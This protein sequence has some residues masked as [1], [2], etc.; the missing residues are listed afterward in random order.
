MLGAPHRGRKIAEAPGDASIVVLRLREAGPRELFRLG[1]HPIEDNRRA[2]MRRFRRGQR[3]RS[4]PSLRRLDRGRRGR[5]QIYRARRLARRTFDAGRQVRIGP[6]RFSPDTRHA[7]SPIHLPRYIAEAL[8]FD[9]G[10]STSED[11]RG[12]LLAL[13]PSCYKRRSRPRWADRGSCAYP[14]RDC[15]PASNVVAPEERPGSRVRRACPAETGKRSGRLSRHLYFGAR[16]AT[17]PWA[18]ARLGRKRGDREWPSARRLKTGEDRWRLVRI[19]GRRQLGLR[20]EGNSPN[21]EGRDQRP[22]DQRLF[23]SH[24]LVPPCDA[25]RCYAFCGRLFFIGRL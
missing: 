3:M 11:R 4:P 23:E 24:M 7:R 21:K 22:Q 1:R 2:P 10:A 5:I 13:R 17:G 9:R 15:L 12:N 19:R 16:K 14:G 20:C 25:Q 18:S 8:R 6:S